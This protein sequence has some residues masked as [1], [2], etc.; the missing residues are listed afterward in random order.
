SGIVA[1]AI[2][3]ELSRTIGPVAILT[4]DAQN[5]LIREAIERVSVKSWKRK[6]G[7]T[8]GPYKCEWE[9]Q[10][11]VVA[12]ALLAE[13][14]LPQEVD[15]QAAIGALSLH[16]HSPAIASAMRRLEHHRRTRG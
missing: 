5:S 14:T 8:F 15:F 3:N 11:E 7:A 2:A 10:D 16:S 6:T 4:P 13:I 1:W 12:D 9:L